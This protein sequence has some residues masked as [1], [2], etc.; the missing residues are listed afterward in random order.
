[1]SKNLDHLKHYDTDRLLKNLEKTPDDKDL[2]DYLVNQLQNDKVFWVSFFEDMSLKYFNSIAKKYLLI[3]ESDESSM[4]NYTI[5]GIFSILEKKYNVKL[6]Y[7]LNKIKTYKLHGKH[8]YLYNLKECLINAV[9]QRS[10]SNRTLDIMIDTFIKQSAKWIDSHN[11]W[12]TFFKLN[13]NLLSTFFKYG[14]RN[15]VK[16]LL[17]DIIIQLISKNNIDLTDIDERPRYLLSKFM[18]L[19]GLK[20]LSSKNIQVEHIKD[21]FNDFIE[22]NY[23]YLINSLRKN[24]L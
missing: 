15:Q 19:S 24:A 3:F 1:M 12:V 20:D 9:S 11:P 2:N 6:Y 7:V 14:D 23:K 18:D 10:M 17:S 8:V 16:H 5:T 13:I 4:V 21:V 22:N